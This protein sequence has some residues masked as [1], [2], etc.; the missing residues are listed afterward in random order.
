MLRDTNDRIP[1]FMKLCGLLLVAQIGY[2]E[3]KNT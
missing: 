2:Y 1:K 3:A